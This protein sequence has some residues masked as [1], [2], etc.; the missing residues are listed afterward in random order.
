M[1]HVLIVEPVVS[2]AEDAEPVEPELDYYDLRHMIQVSS[3]EI[4]SM[5]KKKK[6]TLPARFVSE[7]PS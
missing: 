7:F 3:S 4:S 5:K 1:A 2:Q 6:E